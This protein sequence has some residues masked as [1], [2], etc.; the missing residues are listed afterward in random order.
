MKPI[1]NR[2]VLDKSTGSRESDHTTYYFNWYDN[3]NLVSTEKMWIFFD[4]NGNPVESY[5]ID[6]MVQ[7]RKICCFDFIEP[8]TVEV[9]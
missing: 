4:G 1:V 9:I 3:T 8:I 6:D 2:L 5:N 7:Q